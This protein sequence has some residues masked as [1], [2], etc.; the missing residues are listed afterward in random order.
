MD[1]A[2]TYSKSD[3]ELFTAERKPPPPKARRADPV[4]RKKEKE[5]RD[6]PEGVD[7]PPPKNKLLSSTTPDA[8]KRLHAMLNN[9]LLID[10]ILTKKVNLTLFGRDVGEDISNVHVQVVC[11][12]QPTM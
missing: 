12:I 5:E 11:Q 6:Y 3:L 8:L 7:A 9:F 1:A 2:I 10:G 4:K